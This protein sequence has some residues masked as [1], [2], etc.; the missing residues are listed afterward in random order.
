MSDTRHSDMR[1]NLEIY[2]RTKA[3]TAVLTTQ[4]HAP[5]DCLGGES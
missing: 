4:L 3:Q 1:R 5:S 2:M